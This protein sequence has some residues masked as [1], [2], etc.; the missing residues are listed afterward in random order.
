[1]RNSHFSFLLSFSFFLFFFTLL[2]LT[3]LV[4]QGVKALEDKLEERRQ[5]LG[6]R[7]RHK[8]VRVPGNPQFITHE[9]KDKEKESNDQPV[10]DG[11]SHGEA[12]SGGLAAA[13]RSGKRDGAAQGLLRNGFDKD[14]QGLGLVDG[15]GA[16]HQAANGLGVGQRGLQVLEF[17]R[18]RVGLVARTRRHRLN[19]QRLQDA[20]TKDEEEEQE[21][22][23]ERVRRKEEEEEEEERGR[24][25]RRK[26]T[27]EEEEEEEEEEEK[28]KKEEE[29]EEGE[30]EEEKEEEEE[31]EE[32]EQEKKKKKNK[33]KKEREQTKER[34]SSE[35][36][37][38][39]KANSNN[40]KGTM[41]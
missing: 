38:N 12:Q 10:G 31:E 26:R 24:R 8:D 7:R 2:L 14:D 13:A 34:S 17:G 30:E 28:E 19:V 16:R 29:E 27:K 5:V 3:H 39:K 15:L 22:E 6:A 33:K 11:G 20:K 4:V 32:E 25:G 35:E 40:E 41:G 1:M 37:V 23:E 36:S 18:L 21:E 9:K